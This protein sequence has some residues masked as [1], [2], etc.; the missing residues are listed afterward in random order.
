MSSPPFLTDLDIHL[1]AEGNHERI[2]EKLGAHLTEVDGVE[3]I[4]FA[5]WA[6]NA[7]AVYLVGDFNY[8]KS[9]QHAMKSQSGGVWT[10][11]EPELKA[12]A[13]YKYII[14][15]QTGDVLEKADPYAFAAE[16]RPQTASVVADIDHYQW[17]DQ[18]W[19]ENRK[20][21][22]A[23]NAPIS[24]YEVHLGS[25]RRGENNRFLSYAELAE[26]LIPYVKS[27]G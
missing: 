22:Q 20:E 21:T 17:Y 26:Q 11:F 1:F 9:D 23:L 25:W 24:V 6:P 19:M 5:V 4:H 16:I 12:G 18:D 3:G 7:K 27:L 15:S 13:L 2:Y 14:V 10:R 8:W